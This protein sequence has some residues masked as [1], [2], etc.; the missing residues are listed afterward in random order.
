[1]VVV[2]L[3]VA[4]VS[5]S[6]RARFCEGSPLFS[7]TS[8]ADEARARASISMASDHGDGDDDGGQHQ[9]QGK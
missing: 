6:E 8:A 3:A 7:S 4:A 9:H 5:F 1:V 2:V